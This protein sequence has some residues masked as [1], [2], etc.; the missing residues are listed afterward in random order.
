MSNPNDLNLVGHL[1]ELRTRLIRT[2]IAFLVAMAA[3]FIYVKDI[4]RWLVRG[5]D[6][7]LVVLGPSD[8]M[9]VYLM[10]AGVVAIA[11]TLPIAAYQTWKFVTPALPAV[12]KRSAL[13]FI[14]SISLLFITGLCFGYFILFPMVLHFMDQMA[15]D[16]FAAM[17]TAE[18]YFRFMIHMTVPFGLLFEMPAIVMFLTKIGILNPVRLA[19]ARKLS[20]FILAIVAITIT[21]PDILSDIIVIVPLFLLY[22]ISMTI[23][24]IVY[25]NQLRAQSEWP[26]TTA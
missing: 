9:W 2:L 16:D 5:I 12:A 17:Y 1:D 24:K 6:Q 8:V 25:R 11:V 13:V 10:I 23:S 20:Y 14:P 3:A 7:K 22:E 19:K 4:Y 26:T 18:R 15:G 21:P